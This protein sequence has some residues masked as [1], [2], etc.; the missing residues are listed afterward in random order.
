MLGAPPAGA[1]SVQGTSFF[2]M[3]NDWLGFT[4]FQ[5]LSYLQVGGAEVQ[6]GRIGVYGAAEAAG[7]LRWLVS[8]GAGFLYLSDPQPV[9]MSGPGWYDSPF[10]GE[11]L[12][13]NQ[14]YIVGL[15]ASNLFAWGWN[16]GVLNGPIS[17]IT[18]NGLTLQAR[19]GQAEV[20][21]D[22]SGHFAGNP[23]I[24][25]FESP[26]YQPSLRVLAPIPEPAEWSML[27]AGLLV[28]SFIARRRKQMFAGA[29]EA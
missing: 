25:G 9:S 29:A 22:G 6:I 4:E 5:P 16:D 3:T 15:V 14:T 24:S 18:Q 27:I 21:V 8:D 17:D 1:L 26:D 13:A 28:I 23:I 19:M 7:Q 20:P 2:S 10:I 11:T 12:A